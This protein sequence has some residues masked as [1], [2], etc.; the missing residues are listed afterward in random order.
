MHLRRLQV[1]R[2]QLQ[3][4]P[5]GGEDNEEED[6]AQEVATLLKRIKAA[7]P[8]PEILKVATREAKKLQRSNENHPGHAMARAYLET[9]ADLPW[10]SFAMSRPGASNAALSSCSPKD[11]LGAS[12]RNDGASQR[13]CH[14]PS[15]VAR[16]DAPL[17]PA[18]RSTGP[19]AGSGGSLE[20]A[21]AMLDDQH[22]GLDK[23]KERII[24]YLAVRR[25]RGWDAK[26]PI[27]CF[28]GPPGVGK[29]SLARSIAAVL[30]RPFHRISLGGVRDEAE[31]R[32][33]RRTYIGA[34]PG[35]IIQGLRR[36]GVRDPV[37]LLD[38]VDKMN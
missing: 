37:I 6:E 18:L 4:K 1:A 21:R 28:I 20:A 23:V 17:D 33:H 24:Q 14:S 31:I 10:N 3:G 32:G 13:Q 27:L 5:K 9:L 36:V 12:S 38:E 2:M 11:Q 8:H 30:G 19:F 26:A 25:L 35:R 34:M 16:L 15:L 7:H 22:H 29:T